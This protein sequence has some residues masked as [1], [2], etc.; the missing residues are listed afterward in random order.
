[1]AERSSSVAPLSSAALLRD[2]GERRL[3]SVAAWE[4]RVTPRFAT[5]EISCTARRP[6]ARSSDP[7]VALAAGDLRR[8]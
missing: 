6:V 8:S 3:A 5:R 1:M 2:E 7:V 4:R